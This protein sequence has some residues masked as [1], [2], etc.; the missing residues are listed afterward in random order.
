MLQCKFNSA[1]LKN[2]EVATLASIDW[3]PLVKIIYYRI[4]KSQE[5]EKMLVTDGYFLFVL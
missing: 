1:N 5:N 4:E 3:T 2:K